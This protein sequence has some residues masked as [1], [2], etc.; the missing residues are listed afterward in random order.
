MI[1]ND[2]RRPDGRGGDDGG[3]DLIQG[4]TRLSNWNANVD[5]FVSSCKDKKKLEA[6]SDYS[7]YLVGT[8][9]G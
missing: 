4:C 9:C 8:V 2:D 3:N 1:T 7:V 5:F 6:K